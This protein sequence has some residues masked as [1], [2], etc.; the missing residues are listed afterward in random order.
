MASSKAGLH[1]KAAG[2]LLIIDD[3]TTSDFAIVGAAEDNLGGK[4]LDATSS[5]LPAI[6]SLTDIGTAEDETADWLLIYDNDAA[7]WKKVQCEKFPFMTNY[8]SMSPSVMTNTDTFLVHDDSANVNQLLYVDNLYVYN[9][10][11]RA[12]RNGDTTTGSNASW[13]VQLNAESFDVRGKFD[14]ATN[15]RFQPD[16]SGYYLIHAQIMLGSSPSASFSFWASLFKNGTEHTRGFKADG[17]VLGYTTDQQHP[18]TDLIFL[19]G[20][21]DYVELYLQKSGSNNVN[22]EGSSAYSTFM[23]GARIS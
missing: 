5:G 16:R 11:F 10:G 22:V 14:S 4:E 2:E 15:Y 17:Q 1:Q 9:H 12:Y 6:G 20:T 8:T 21:S 3:L 23:C 18:V 13:K 7:T 19:N